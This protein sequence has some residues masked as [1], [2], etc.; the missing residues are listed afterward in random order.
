MAVTYTAQAACQHFIRDADEGEIFEWTIAIFRDQGTGPVQ[1]G[2][3]VQR[4][5]TALTNQDILLD[6]RAKAKVIVN[7]DYDSIQQATLDA[8]CTA[9]TTQIN[10]FSE[11]RP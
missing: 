1:I 3:I 8:R 7:A 5:S 11:T 6:L 4:Y 9:M 2:Q 10:G